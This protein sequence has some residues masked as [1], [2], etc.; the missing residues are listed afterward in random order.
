MIEEIKQEHK[1]GLI[2]RILGGT[3]TVLQ[4]LF[5]TLM[6]ITLILWPLGF[7]ISIFFFDAPI[8]SDIDKICRYG[9]LTTIWLY[10]IYLFPLLRFMFQLSKKLRATWLYYLCPTVPI[11]ILW[12]LLSIS[13]VSAP[14][15]DDTECCTHDD[16][17]G[18]W[19]LNGGERQIN[20]PE[21]EFLNDSTVELYSRADTV[22]RY[23][24]CLQNDSLYL[25]DTNGRQYVN[26]INKVD[27]ESSMF[28]GIADV[29]SI[30]IYHK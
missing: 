21:I 17:I 4:K 22:Y 29:K 13:T 8:H 11:I 3:P 16:L 28:E 1:D 7:Y 5:F 14:Q 19:T 20:Y 2:A 12:S 30:Q 27:D 23:T 18:H 26:K 6:A 24:Y 25:T 9:M 10:P 15:I